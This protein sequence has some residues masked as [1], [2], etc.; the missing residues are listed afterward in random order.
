MSKTG[1][2]IARTIPLILLF[3]LILFSLPRTKKLSFD[4]KKGSPWKHDDLVATFSFPILKPEEQIAQEKAMNAPEAVPY[5]RRSINVEEKSLVAAEGLDLGAYD[6]L[7]P[8][9]ISTIEDIY[10]HGVMDDSELSETE[11]K[12]SGSKIIYVQ[13][14]KKLETRP[15][16]EVYAL[17]DANRVLKL[18]SLNGFYD[19]EID[20]VLVS[21]G[22]YDLLSTNLEYDKQVTDRMRE[23]STPEVSPTLGYVNAGQKIVA[24]GETVTAE[25]AQIINSYEKEYIN[26]VKGNNSSSI[27][28]WIGNGI[29]ALVLVLLL[30]FSIQHFNSSIFLD[31]GKYLYLVLIFGIFTICAIMVPQQHP[32]IVFAIPFVLCALLLEAFFDN[33]L[34][35]NVYA[36]AI[37]PLMLFADNGAATYFMFLMAGVVS[38]ICFKHFNK[39]WRQFINALI[40][41]SVLFIIYLGLHFTEIVSGNIFHSAILLI[42]SS[43]LCV[44]GYPLSYLFE[45]IFNLVSVY[46]LNELCDTSNPLLH[47]LEQKA[48]GTFQH[49]LQVMNMASAVAT[50]IGANKQL[51]RAGALYHDIG[52]MQN[53]LCFVENESMLAGEGHPRYHE[54]MTPVQSAQDII[55]HVTDGLELADKARLPRVVKDFILTHHGTACV[56]YFY[57]KF[58]N[59]GGDPAEQALFCYPGKKPVSKEQVI[60]MLCDSVE[61]AS[62]TLS[63]YSPETFDKFVEGIVAGKQEEDQFSEAEISVKD[64][65]I[66]KSALKSYLAQMYHERIAYPKRK[67]Q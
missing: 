4:Y 10:S 36:I 29:I 17:S 44:A 32:E 13:N 43:F 2:Y 16:S 26:S 28:T 40:T 66:V 21:A 50:K 7:K 67:N 58:L 23:A 62:R 14:G 52:K 51:I 59:E 31:S 34:V 30:F 5:Y 38:I 49:C 9:I 1:S 47:S 37:L 48:P 27:L 6:Y 19:D 15:I 24:S 53:P 60:L 46:R 56:S 12:E 11:G 39:G 22:F 25:I 8:D 55:H 18:E 41:F 63:N 57:T 65:G 35:T 3:V 20:S 42:V 33:R 45:K 54:G 61:A 64:L